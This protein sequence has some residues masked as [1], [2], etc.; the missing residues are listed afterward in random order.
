M[1]VALS[2]A[3]STGK[4]TLAQAFAQEKKDLVVLNVDARRVL[5]AMGLRNTS[6]MGA[7]IYTRFQRRYAARKIALERNVEAY[8][9]ERSFV[10]SYV[11]WEHHCADVATPRQNAQMLRLCRRFAEAYDVH[12]YCPYG[13]VP[14]EDDGYRNPDR[15]YHEHTAVRMLYYLRAWRLH[16]VS[17]DSSALAERLALLRQVFKK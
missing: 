4:T 17:L 8:L 1:R 6:E 13:L 9:A 15:A 12:V 5:D 2:G 14:H 10:D 11:Y 7:D 3:S 16:F